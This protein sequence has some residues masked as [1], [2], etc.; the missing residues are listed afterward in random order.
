MAIAPFV[1]TLAGVIVFEYIDLPTWLQLVAAILLFV[2]VYITFFW[3]FSMN[4]YEREI[5][6]LPLGRV[7]KHFRV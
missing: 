4:S 2:C 7:V 5:V 3:R 1:L 6:T